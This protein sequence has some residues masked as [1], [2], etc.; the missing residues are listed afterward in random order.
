MLQRKIGEYKAQA[1][2]DPLASIEIDNTVFD[3]PFNP[4]EMLY[5]TFT[6]MNLHIE[7]LRGIV[8]NIKNSKLVEKIPKS[9]SIALDNIFKNI[10]IDGIQQIAKVETYQKELMAYPKHV[11]YYQTRMDSISK[12]ILSKLEMS[13]QKAMKYV[14]F[15]EMHTTI[16][17]L[18]TKLGSLLQNITDFIDKN[19]ESFQSAFNPTQKRSFD[20]AVI[21]INTTKSEINDIEKSL[22][23]LQAFLHNPDSM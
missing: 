1:G 23:K 2:I 5:K 14:M 11:A 7:R 15:Y 18:Y 6:S 10:E 12:A 8:M 4:D 16:K 13:S 19:I 22:L 17:M 21:S 3:E 9:D 20:D